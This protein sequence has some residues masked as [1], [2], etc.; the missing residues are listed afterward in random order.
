MDSTLMGDHSS[1]EVD[2]VVNSTVK[3][4][5]VGKRGFQYGYTPAPH[6][7]IY[8]LSLG[9][10]HPGVLLLG[11]DHVRDGGHHGVLILGIL[12]RVLL[13]HLVSAALY[14]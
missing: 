8:I 1:V 12:H 6:K 9:L 13:K 5:G 3:I 2:A 10:A 11:R 4:S 14:H 7:K